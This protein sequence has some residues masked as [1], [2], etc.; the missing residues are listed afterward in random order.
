MTC[1]MTSEQLDVA[2]EKGRKARILDG[3]LVQDDFT[4]EKE[5]S[6]GQ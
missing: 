4:L 3:N 6:C 1:K 5:L 2:R